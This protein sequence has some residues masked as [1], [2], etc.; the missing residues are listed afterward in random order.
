MVQRDERHVRREEIRRLFQLFRCNAANVCSLPVYH[1]GILPQGL[2]Q[3]SVSH[4]NGVH[5]CSS[6]LE[7][8]VGKTAGRCSDIQTDHSL[9]RE[10]HLLYRMFQFQTAPPHK[11]N[12]TALHGDPVGFRN[13]K[14]RL[15]T[16]LAVHRDL[17]VLNQRFGTLAAGHHTLLYHYRIK[18]CHVLPPAAYP[19]KWHAPTA[20]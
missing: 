12:V 4:V 1:A 9:Q 13:G 5:L 20:P 17:P 18:P 10:P 2:H 16:D 11:G 8:A 14:R 6:V 15:G 3:L 7:H 19:D